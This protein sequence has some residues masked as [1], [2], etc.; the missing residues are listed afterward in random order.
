[1]KILQA[2]QIVAALLLVLLNSVVI[3]ESGR[4]DTGLTLQQAVA[5]TL[6]SNPQLIAAGHQL[7]T[8]R[9]AVVQ[10]GLK[11][12]PELD[13]VTENVLGSNR[14]T[15]LDNSESTLSVAW[16]LERAKREQRVGT[17]EAGVARSQ[18]AVDVVR[19][20]AAAQTARLFIESLNAAANKKHFVEAVAL[21]EKAVEAVKK[22]VDAGRTPRA[23]LARAEAELALAQLDV[24]DITHETESLHRRLAAQWGD[25]QPR[26]SSVAGTLDQT[27]TPAS[28]ARLLEQTADN[29]DI[30]LYSAETRLREAE[31]KLIRAEVKPGWRVTA[32]VKHFGLGDEV[33]LMA[34]FSVPLAISDRRQGDVASA[35][36]SLAVTRAEADALSLRIGT[37]LFVLHQELLHSLHQTDVLQRDVIPRIDAALEDARAAYVAGRYGYLELRTVQEELLAARFALTDARARAHLNVIDIERLTGKALPVA[38]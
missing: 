23:D 14:F 17:A 21:A 4:S 15:G 18:A 28:F 11:P 5:Q 12:N 29:P 1:M 6:A 27:P 33:A 7:G 37:Q 35:R 36:A 38:N 22:R 25:P 2:R 24:D 10:A 8:S 30:R 34:G 26:F 3:A 9:G 13:L 16:Q 19:F 20:D 32:G 31:L